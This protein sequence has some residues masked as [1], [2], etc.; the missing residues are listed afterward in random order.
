M[1]DCRHT[2]AQY[3][4]MVPHNPLSPVRTERCLQPNM[5]IL[6]FALPE[7]PIEE[8]SLPKSDM[9]MGIPQHDG[10][11]SLMIPDTPSIGVELKPDAH[12]KCPNKLHKVVTRPHGTGVCWISMRGLDIR[13]SNAGPHMFLG[14]KAS[15]AELGSLVG[16]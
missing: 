4:G 8:D 9:V 11:G 13:S 15:Y 10:K 14:E 5:Y 6:S 16:Q 3:V 2:E 12:E 7:Y 1:G